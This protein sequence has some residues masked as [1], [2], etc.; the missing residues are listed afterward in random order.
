MAYIEA[1]GMGQTATERQDA[2]AK[3]E[4]I[5]LV[6]EVMRIRRY[7]ICLTQGIEA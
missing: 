4:I 5:T 6:A 3:Q 2:D 7:F 1:L